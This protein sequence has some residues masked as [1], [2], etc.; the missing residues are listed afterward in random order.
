MFS[1]GLG[2]VCE[3]GEFGLEHYLLSSSNDDD[4][5]S[6][7]SERTLHACMADNNVV[8]KRRTPDMVKGRGE[9]CHLP[10]KIGP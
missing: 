8:I 3:V 4:S 9:P 2:V 6:R 10:S 1:C 7:R 5:G